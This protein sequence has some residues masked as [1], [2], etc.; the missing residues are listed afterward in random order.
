MAAGLV[1][2]DVPL[3]DEIRSFLELAATMYGEADPDATVEAVFTEDAIYAD[4]RPLA[5]GVVEGWASLKS[6]L[7]TTLQV[8][9][10]FRV[11]VHVLAVDG[12]RYLARDTY[13]GHT[14]LGGGEAEMQWWVV[15]QLRDGKLAREDIFATE[16]EARAAFDSGPV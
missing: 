10:D 11:R 1:T 14:T 16:A 12:S 2:S 15:D 4:H 8:L 3:P 13:A 9:P 5:G 7:R 6:Q